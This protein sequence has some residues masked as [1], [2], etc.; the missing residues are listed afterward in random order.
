MSEKS[1]SGEGPLYLDSDAW[2]LLAI[3]YAGREEPAALA[4]VIAAADY[5]NHAIVVFEEMEGALARLS[6]GGY[7][8]HTEGKLSPTEKSLELYR[9]ITKPRRAVMAE[10]EDLRQHLDAPQGSP[11]KPQL[12]NSGVSYPLLIR[13]A[14]DEALDNYLAR[15]RRKKK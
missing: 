15:H 3:I 12:A 13:A 10:W 9:S 11:Q 7:I 4:D 6:E 5:I 2:L 14:F 8:T 1:A